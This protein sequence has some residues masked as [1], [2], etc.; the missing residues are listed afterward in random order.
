MRPKPQ[1]IFLAAPITLFLLI[2]AHWLP[3]GDR[4]IDGWAYVL[5]A[6]AGGSLAMSRW[7]AVG[8]W[9]ANL[10]ALTAYLAVGFPH[11]PIFA[12]AWIALAMLARK[13]PRPWAIA[14]AVTTCVALSA[15]EASTSHGRLWL[16]AVFVGWS[17]AAVFLGD[18]V[19]NR[20]LY[21]AEEQRRRQSVNDAEL[22][23]QRRLAAAERLRIAH[24]LHDGVAHAMTIINV[25]ASAAAHVVDSNPDQAREALQAIRKASATVLDE[26]GVMMNLLRD[27][28]PS[29]APAPDLQSVPQLISEV[30]P[31]GLHVSFTTIDGANDLPSPIQRTIY[32]VLQEALTNVTRHSTATQVTATLRRDGDSLSFIVTDDGQPRVTGQSGTGTGLIIM[33]ERVEAT[34]GEFSTIA[35]ETGFNVRADWQLS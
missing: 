35:S 2:T 22:S 12:T 33:R 31:L 1:P 26:L 21:F 5:L 29:T 23:E 14:A 10:L 13:V 7:N 19:K 18:S 9:T 17:S 30:E 11:G 20:R 16:V 34:N 25:Q 28:D 24:D 15:A 32:R 4:D 27:D 8:A 6:I 3:G